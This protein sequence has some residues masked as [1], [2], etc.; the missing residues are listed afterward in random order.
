MSQV[1]LQAER[2]GQELYKSEFY[3]KVDQF[4]KSHAKPFWEVDQGFPLGGTSQVL[5]SH[6]IDIYQ[7]AG[8][9]PNDKTGKSSSLAI[10][11]MTKVTSCHDIWKSNQYGTQEWRPY[12][13]QSIYTVDYTNKYS[14]DLQGLATL[15]G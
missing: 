12:I 6:G 5:T 3:D 11:P 1:Q 14:D 10:N 13:C 7:N 8:M 4:K 2:P 9:H 15:R